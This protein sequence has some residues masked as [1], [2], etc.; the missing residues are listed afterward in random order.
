[1]SEKLTGSCKCGQIRYEISPERLVAANCHCNMCKKMTGGAFSSIVLVDDSTFV[2][3]DGE[4]LLTHYTVSERASKHFCSRCGS[5]VFSRHIGF[6]GK[7]LIAL[8]TLDDPTAV[9]PG[10]NVFC[11]SILRWAGAVGDLP[12]FDREPP[13]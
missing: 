10:V 13:R 9:T 11:E 2:L 6:P 4:E 1:M 7:R 5:P 3:L 12:S 8:G